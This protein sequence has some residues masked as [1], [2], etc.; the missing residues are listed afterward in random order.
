MLARLK[1][2]HV[3]WIN[4]FLVVF[5]VALCLAETKRNKHAT[6]EDIVK[7]ELE[8]SLRQFVGI[9]LAIVGLFIAAS[10]GIGGGGILV[11]IYILVSPPP[12]YHAWGRCRGA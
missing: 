12:R 1:P 3:Q 8:A 11:P 2:N 7:P 4:V 6:D 9:F 5:N 10:S